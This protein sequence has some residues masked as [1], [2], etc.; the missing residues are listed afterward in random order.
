MFANYVQDITR[1]QKDTYIVNQYP[2]LK[3]PKPLPKDHK[4]YKYYY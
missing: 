4:D 1:R 3:S 2:N